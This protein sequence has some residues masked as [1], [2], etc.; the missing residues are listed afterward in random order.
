MVYKSLRA[1]SFFSGI[2]VADVATVFLG[3]ALQESVGTGSAIGTF[4][5]AYACELDASCQDHLSALSPPPAHLF[6][7]ILDF[8]PDKVEHA[9][10]EIQATSRTPWR[11]LVKLVQDSQ[12]RESVGCTMHPMSTCRYETP[13]VDMSGSPCQDWTRRS[14]NPQGRNGNGHHC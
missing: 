4:D 5:C 7:S 3:A 12:I 8:L 9:T 10:R 11:S 2:G 1:G 6:R 14:N 13:D